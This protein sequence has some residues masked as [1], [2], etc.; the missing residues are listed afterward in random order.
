[1]FEVGS[2]KT[3]RVQF[4]VQGE[5]LNYFI[6][7]GPTPKE[8]LMRY[9]D[10]TGKPA[11]PPAKSF[12]LWLSTS[13]CTNYD[14]ETVLS[15]IDQMKANDIPFDTFHFDCFWM[16]AF[17][18]TSFEFDKKMFPDPE[19]LIK[20]IR[21]RNINV[22]LWINP[23][24]G[25][26]AKVFKECAQKGYL[27]KR[28]DG[29]IWQTD[30]WQAGMAVIDFT[31]EEA[32]VWYEKQLEKL[33]KMG[34]NSFKTDFGE[35]IPLNVSYHNG[36]NSAKMHNYYSFMYNK[37]VFNCLKRLLGEDEAVL[38][39]RSATVGGQQF[40][41]HWGGD[42]SATFTSMAESL[43]GGLSFGLSGFGFWSHDIA[44]FEDEASPQL[45]QRWSQF[46]FLSSHTRYHGN[47]SYKVPW[48]YGEQSL[49]VTRQFSQLKN[50]L[51][52]YLYNQ[53]CYTAQS[54]IP[55]MRPMFLEFGR[56]YTTHTLD[57][58][59]MLGRSLLVAP[60]FNDKGMAHYYLPQNTIWTNLLSNEMKRGGTWYTEQ[61]SFDTMPL[62]VRQD[63]MLLMGNTT[64]T[65]CYDYNHNVE[66]HIY[67]LSERVAIDSEIYNNKGVECAKIVVIR[68]GSKINF[69]TEGLTGQTKLVMHNCSLTK[70]SGGSFEHRDNNTIISLEIDKIEIN[71]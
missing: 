31:K 2:E 16:E 6:I 67:Y 59:Y 38:F 14:E 28:S 36:A 39:A 37:L 42:N 11:L 40:P 58:Q 47:T 3:Q 54:G 34:V 12:G 62:F 27:L 20:A 53:A 35:R 65:A 69:R 21:E 41:V 15:F 55:M 64:G 23:Y 61:Y 43:R 32:C 17:E 5:E 24:I 56:D 18:W 66:V 1:M 9:T 44:G 49:A 33:V 4:A 29:S 22:C 68:D 52:P 51:M 10:L 13:F 25:Q 71:L 63:S 8:V 30:L 46:G 57:R 45:Y 70:I 7:N 60:I 50:R 26:Q 19:K 48:L